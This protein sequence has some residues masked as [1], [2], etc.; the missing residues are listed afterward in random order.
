MGALLASLAM[1]AVIPFAAAAQPRSVPVPHGAFGGEL[2][3]G[4]LFYTGYRGGHSTLERFDLASAQ[5]TVLY[6]PRDRRGEIVGVEAGGGSLAIQVE[7]G[8]QRDKV[9]ALDPLRGAPALIASGRTFERRGCGRGVKLEDVS[10]SG[11]I[12]VSQADVRCGRR[13]GTFRVRAYRPVGRPLTLERRATDTPAISDGGPYR[14]LEGTHFLSWWERRA[15]V[16]DLATGTLRRFAVP[17]PLWLLSSADVDARG[18]VLLDEVR[19]RGR[20]YRQ[21][22]RLAGPGGQGSAGRVV[23]DSPDIHRAS[24]AAHFCGRHVVLHAWAV[25]RERL[26]LVEPPLVLRDGRPH[27]V[28]FE[29]TCDARQYVQLDADRDRAL[30]YDLPE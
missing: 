14:T 28:D 8:F 19:W 2:D 6:A 20:T 5:R 1:S 21:R 17:G 10:E 13:H 16:R 4:A 22:V 26:F 30:V 29:P 7:R 25:R 24:V 23:F 12:V 3:R 18:R 9:L 27:A 11:D 15:R